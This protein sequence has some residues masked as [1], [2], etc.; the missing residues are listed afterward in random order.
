[1][2]SAGSARRDASGGRR[3]GERAGLDV[4][5]IVEAASALDPSEITMRRVAARLGVDHK[6]LNHHVADRETLMGL[7]AWRAFA[8]HFDADA[9][10]SADWKSAC[11]D[12][13]EAVVDA[14]VAVGPLIDHLSL[15]GAPLTGFVLRTEHFVGTLVA[16]GF[17]DE[18]ALRA[19]VI[20]TNLCIAHAR[21]VVTARTLATHP[22]S[23]V[24]RAAFAQ[25]ADSSPDE[26]FPNLTRILDAQIDTYS[27]GQFTFALAVIV[28]GLALIAGVPN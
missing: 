6:A 21:D 16:A 14:A 22:R 19:T 5:R 10:A 17:T 12:Y 11:V 24:V 26:D 13:A 8:A 1:M 7:L 15:R 27:H 18:Q 9:P 4:D 2:E 28:N 3:Q 25:S 20:L 23:D